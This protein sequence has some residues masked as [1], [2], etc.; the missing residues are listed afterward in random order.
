MNNYIQTMYIFT[1]LKYSQGSVGAVGGNVSAVGYTAPEETTGFGYL[2][3]SPEYAF[4]YCG[5]IKRWDAKFMNKGTLWLQVWRHHKVMN[6]RLVQETPVHVTK[7]P[8][9]E[10]MTSITTQDIIHFDKGDVIG[11]KSEA[12]EIIPFRSS[13]VIV[14]GRGF[15]RLGSVPDPGGLVDWGQGE[16]VYGRQYAVSAIIAHIL[17]SW[18]SINLQ[19]NCILYLLPSLTASSSSLENI[20]SPSGSFSF[21]GRQLLHIL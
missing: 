2:A 4:P 10:Q 5:T 9:L 11:W 18:T 21:V 12:N 8:T 14:G 19:F 3:T 17:I 15:W 6:Y 7:V 16:F 1:Y 20:I 13:P